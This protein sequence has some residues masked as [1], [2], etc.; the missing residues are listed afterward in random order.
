[1]IKYYDRVCKKIKNVKAIFNGIRFFIKVHSGGNTVME[2]ILLL[3]GI[4][5]D[6]ICLGLLIF[7]IVRIY[8]NN[9]NNR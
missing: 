5:G 8:K 7:W 6:V 3:A 4:A 9:K 1:M 2:K